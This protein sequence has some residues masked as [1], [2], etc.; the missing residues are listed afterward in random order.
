MQL[1]S[2]LYQ[3]GMLKVYYGPDSNINQALLKAREWA[4]ER[5]AEQPECRIANYL[6]PHC[7]IVSG[8]EEV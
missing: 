3:G 5:G 1:A 8:C 7:V 2:E 4:L 6:Y